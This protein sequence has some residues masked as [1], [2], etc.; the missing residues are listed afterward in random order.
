MLAASREIAVLGSCCNLIYTIISIAKIK[1]LVDKAMMQHLPCVI[2]FPPETIRRFCRNFALA[3]S[4]VYHAVSST[5]SATM[6]YFGYYYTELS[7]TVGGSIA[8]GSLAIDTTGDNQPSLSK[9]STVTII[10]KENLTTN[11]PNQSPIFSVEAISRI[12][13]WT[14]GRSLFL[15]WAVG[16]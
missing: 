10:N 14:I 12:V 16:R 2:T 1:R 15:F 6:N 8:R 5:V 13:N 7:C 3:T 4:K 11:S 9:P